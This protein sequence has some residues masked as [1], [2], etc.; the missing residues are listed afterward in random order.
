MLDP[1]LATNLTT[2]L[3]NIAP[4]ASPVDS[5]LSLAPTDIEV[6]AD[7][8]NLDEDTIALVY[9]VTGPLNITAVAVGP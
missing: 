4:G 6:L 8:L 2:I 7:A 1:I 5:L 3:Q 9:A